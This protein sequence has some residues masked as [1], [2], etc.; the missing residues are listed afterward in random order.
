[1]KVR[2]LATLRNITDCKGV[3]LEA[4]NLQQVIDILIDN[5]GKDMEDELL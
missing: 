3:E 1:M 5:Y 4:E 2:L